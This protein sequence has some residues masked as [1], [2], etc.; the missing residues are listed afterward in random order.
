M[1]VCILYPSPVSIHCPTINTHTAH[2]AHAAHLYLEALLLK[3][4]HQQE[5]FFIKLWVVVRLDNL[6]AL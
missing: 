1:L 4:I 2:A 3:V 5:E 6:A